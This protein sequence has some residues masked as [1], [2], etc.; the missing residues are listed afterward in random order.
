MATLPGVSYAGDR[1]ANDDDKSCFKSSTLKQKLA[2]VYIWR[3]AS[4]KIKQNKKTPLSSIAE[5]ARERCTFMQ[6]KGGGGGDGQQMSDKKNESR[7]A[8]EGENQ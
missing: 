7:D 5:R 2:H 3:F 6:G 4:L 1:N 8:N